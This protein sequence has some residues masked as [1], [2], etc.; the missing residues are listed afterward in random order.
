[1]TGVVIDHVHGIGTVTIA[2][3][4]F[5]PRDRG[6]DRSRFLGIGTVTIAVISLLLQY[7][8]RDHR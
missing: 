7:R 3:I 8:D 6:R 5:L 4:R 2:V 1:M